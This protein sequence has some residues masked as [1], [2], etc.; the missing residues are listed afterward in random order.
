MFY[1]FERLGHMHENNF[2]F[3]ILFG[4]ISEKSSILILDLYLYTIKI[5]TS[6][7]QNW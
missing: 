6:I 5:Q 2:F 4:N 7:N 3:Y 1:I